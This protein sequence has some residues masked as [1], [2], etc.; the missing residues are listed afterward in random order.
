[1]LTIRKIKAEDTQSIAD[2]IRKS[3]IRYRDSSSPTSKLRWMVNVSNSQLQKSIGSRTKY[4]EQQIGHPSNKREFLVIEDNNK[5][6]G[7]VRKYQAGNSA[8][9]YLDQKYYRRGMQ[10]LLIDKVEQSY[11]RQVGS[12]F[13]TKPPYSPTPIFPILKKPVGIKSIQSSP[14]QLGPKFR[15]KDFR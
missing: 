3:P 4:L 5:I 10:K 11:L 8:N 12:R 14:N 9:L 7:V 2:L 15:S 13:V 6:V 1:M